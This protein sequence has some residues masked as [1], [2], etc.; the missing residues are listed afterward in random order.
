MQINQPT[1]SKNF[2]VYHPD[3]YLQLNMFREF[4]CPSSGAQQLQWQTL[5]LPIFI[6][7]IFF[8]PVA[9]RPN[10]GHGLL[11]LEVL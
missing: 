6:R 10:A 8:S 9:L 3:V 4:P 1:R 11:I 2:P 5:V 7:D